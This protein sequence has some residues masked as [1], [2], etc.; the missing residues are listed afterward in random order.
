MAF[1]A[2]FGDRDHF[3]L[4]GRALEAFIMRAG[5]PA[6]AE[7]ADFNFIPVHFWYSPYAKG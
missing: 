5:N 7:K 2:R 1:G 3:N 4:V 6:A